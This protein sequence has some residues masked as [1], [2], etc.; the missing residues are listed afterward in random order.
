MAEVNVDVNANLKLDYSEAMNEAKAAAD[1]LKALTDQIRLKGLATDI[2]SVVAE[3]KQ[4]EDAFN[5]AKK[6]IPFGDS[7]AETT[8]GWKSAEEEFNSYA[9]SFASKEAYLQ[10]FKN[11]SVEVKNAINDMNSA[12]SSGTNEELRN[13]VTQADALRTRISQIQ[14]NI[15]ATTL[16]DAERG[17]LSPMYANLSSQLDT[18]TLRMQSA[19]K[20][21]LV[22][23]FNEALKVVK[24]SAKKSLNTLGKGLKSVFKTSA[25]VFSSAFGSVINYIGKRFKSLFTLGFNGGTVST[26]LRLMSGVG[27]LAGIKKSVEYSSDMVESVN[28]LYYVFGDANEEILEFAENSAKYFGLTQNLALQFASTYGGILSAS[29]IADDKLAFMSTN[30]T[31]IVGDLSSFYD[32][33]QDVFFSKLQAGISGNV[34]ALRQYGIN[35]SVANLETYRLS[36]GI[37]TSYQDM[38][39]A[40]KTI[41]RYNYIIES[42][43]KAQGDFSRTSGTWAN[44]IRQLKNN[45]AQL[46]AVLG[47]IATKILLPVVKVLNAIVV[48]ATNAAKALA[49]LFGA[50]L[51]SLQEIT[52]SGIGDIGD[53][54]D[55]SDAYNNEADALDNVG[56]SAKKAGDNLQG[57]DRLNNIKTPDTSGADGIG[58]VTG[59]D[60]GL[61]P[62]DWEGL[63]GDKGEPTEFEKWMDHF[64][65]LLESKRWYDA[66]AY[67]G[68]ALNKINNKL[69][70]AL[71]DPRIKEG[72]HNFNGAILEFLNGLLDFTSWRLVGRVFGALI[73]DIIFA[74]NDLYAQAVEKGT[75]KKIG[76]A[77]AEFVYGLVDEIDWTA[78]GQAFMTGFRALMDMIAGF[79]SQAKE[80]GLGDKIGVAIKNFIAGA[81]NRVFAN[82]GAEEIGQNI[83]DFFNLVFKAVAIGIGDKRNINELRNG[84]VTTINTAISELSKD[85]LQGALEGLLRLF[86]NLFAAIGDFDTDTLSTKI[87]DAINGSVDSG[88]V[89]NFASGLTSALINIINLIGSTIEK[90]DM[91]KL[92]I[93]I[94]KGIANGLITTDGEQYLVKAFGILFGVKLVSSVGKLGIHKLVQAILLKL[95]GGLA[96]EAGATAVSTSLGKT[97]GTALTSVGKSLVSKAV[98]IGSNIKTGLTSFA[99]ALPGV[100]S[101]LSVFGSTLS[102][103]GIA[104]GT[105]AV[106]IGTV[107]STVENVKDISKKLSIDKLSDDTKELAKSLHSVNDTQIRFEID[108]S[109]FIDLNHYTDTLDLVIMEYENIKTLGE[110]PWIPIGD[111]VVSAKNL[112]KAY[113]D[114]SQTTIANTEAFQHFADAVKAIDTADS[115]SA[116]GEAVREATKQLQILAEDAKLTKAD[117][118]NLDNIEY[119]ALNAQLTN[120]KAGVAFTSEELS[121][122]TGQWREAGVELTDELLDSISQ[123]LGTDVAINEATGQLL[124]GIEAVNYANAQQSGAK[125]ATDVVDGY[126]TSAISNIEMGAA[127]ATSILNATAAADSVAS[128]GGTQ[129]ASSYANGYEQ[130]IA[131]DELVDSATRQSIETATSDENTGATERGTLVGD[132]LISS[133]AT[134]IEK[135]TELV[136]I[137]RAKIE[138]ATNASEAT[139]S[140]GG[141]E[142]GEQIPAGIESGMNGNSGSLF[143]SIGSLCS[144][145]VN[146]FKEKL[147]IHSPSGIFKYWSKFIPEGAAEGIDEG[148][149]ETTKAIGNMC[150]SMVNEM[151]G[152]ELDTQSLL[153]EGKF[154]T[155][156]DSLMRQTDIAVAYITDKFAALRDVMNLQSSMT[157]SPSFGSA[158]LQAAYASASDNSAIAQSLGNMYSRMVTGGIQSSKPVQVNVYLDKGNKLASYV[159]D[160][161]K[162]NA[163]KTGDF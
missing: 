119:N 9:N 24:D 116:R 114:L 134:A 147:D 100:I 42:A 112:K 4:L 15:Q 38:D 93:A 99:T 83:A 98:L 124:T 47:G 55:T 156:F 78:A 89:S 143:S 40:N 155:M 136:D 122:L 53:V 54:E 126:V 154:D 133:I 14:A 135:M 33:D 110:N 63:L 161:V 129:N 152:V 49:R 107:M 115:V 75:L 2:K 26:L 30:L 140:S 10:E 21:R 18:A 7:F 66:G 6:S 32:V 125:L 29:G 153:P 76:K 92:V 22:K 90:V 35:V 71:T 74:I 101:Q 159:I 131:L 3:A 139:A 138:D 127:T 52:G 148:A 8:S 158:S 41:L 39:Q 16:S 151:S 104:L 128:Q 162:G 91:T 11:L 69:Y 58:G 88:E 1:G 31:K 67:L 65:G 34:Q 82:G 121:V 102:G 105:V 79:F 94:L 95:A 73:N 108:P 28:R 80:I 77:F 97:L 17:S 45:F 87:A 163:I 25:K 72:I 84:I 106:G 70:N 144:N 157:L 5:R 12:L 57:F 48:A 130:S 27:L 59:T 51:K 81:I 61:E 109:L 37:Q 23:G 111:G 96:G 13:A 86:G 50:D 160:T 141:R 19:V 113:D 142:I 62:L 117:L 56:E 43:S 137:L 44:Q 60:I 85:D 103:V 20:E 46:L 118:E 36:K 146:K 149:V 68:Q 132:T 120:L 123:K 150:D 145:I 64:L